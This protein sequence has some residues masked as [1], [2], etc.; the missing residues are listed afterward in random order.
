M[1]SR[2]VFNFSVISQQRSVLM[3]IATLLVVIFHSVDLSTKFLPLNILKGLLNFIKTNGEVGV[4]IFLLLSG[5][6]LYYSLE[7]DKSLKRFY[8]KRFLRVVPSIFIVAILY[9][10]LIPHNSGSLA[11]FCNITFVAFFING[12]RTFWYF[13]LLL[14]LYF[15][16]PFIHRIIRRYKYKGF[17]L[18]VLIALSLNIV[19]YFLFHDY[20]MLVEIALT[21]IPIFITGALLGCLAKNCI[22]CSLLKTIFISVLLFLICFFLLYYFKSFFISHILYKRGIES[23]FSIAITILLS[24]IFSLLKVGLIRRLLVFVGIYSMEIYLL[25]ER[26]IFFSYGKILLDCNNVCYYFAAFVFTL[27]LA[28]ILKMVTDMIIK[29]TE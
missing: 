17:A 16:Y 18:L 19:G 4:D 26:V 23:I 21:R 22:R 2:K 7:K 28:I 3:G 20:Y 8:K 1:S 13:S 15:V 5:F 6:G 14:L 12:S 10:A 9:N 25:Y 29:R 11:F 27:V 24:W